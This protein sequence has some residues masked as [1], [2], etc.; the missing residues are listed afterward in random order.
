M[1]A[2]A[3]VRSQP[4][5][6]LSRRWW[7]GGVGCEVGSAGGGRLRARRGASRGVGDELAGSAARRPGDDRGCGVGGWGRGGGGGGRPPEGRERGDKG[8]AD[9]AEPRS[10]C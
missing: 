8:E 6:K 5:A 2:R 4:A 9:T 7:A 10:P 3:P 1:P